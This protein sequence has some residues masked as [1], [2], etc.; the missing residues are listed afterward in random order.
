MVENDM[1]MRKKG[2]R[3]TDERRSRSSGVYIDKKAKKGH[4]SY[5]SARIVS[6]VS[7]KKLLFGMRAYILAELSLCS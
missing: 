2:K 5:M 6:I 1:I 4:G 7:H 3:G